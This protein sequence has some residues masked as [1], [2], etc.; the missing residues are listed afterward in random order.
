MKNILKGLVSNDFLSI[1][2]AISLVENDYPEKEEL[3]KSLYPLKNKAHRIGITGPPGAGKSSITNKLIQHYLSKNKKIAVLLVDPSS[4]FTK[5]AV[6][7]DRIRMNTYYENPNI[8]IRSLA[9][10]GHKG[11]LV[12]NIN[13][14]SN[15][16]E[17][18]NFDIIIFETVG[19]GQ[20]EL[21]VVE[22]VDTVAVVLVP[23]SGDDIQIMKAGLIEIA[24]IFVVNKYDRKDGDK[25]CLVLQNMLALIQNKE[26]I[27]KINKTIA[28]ENKGIEDLVKNIYNH[29]KYLLDN[30]I[31]SNNNNKRIVNDINKILN[32]QY[33]KEFWTDDRKKYLEKLLYQSKDAINPYDVINKL[34]T[35]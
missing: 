9:S 31:I 26:Y 23:E 16:L 27:P 6:L 17:F 20:I 30:D 33:S 15:I 28:I 1:A 22:S 14:I 24:D 34:K 5:G 4:P 10:R 13:E 35:L 18:S 8:F 3:I 21:D 7:G 11:G 29:R 25:L 2:K 32:N 19:V 12:K